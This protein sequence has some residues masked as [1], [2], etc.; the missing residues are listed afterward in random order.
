MLA[1][2]AVARTTLLAPELAGRVVLAVAARE[3]TRLLLGL[4]VLLIP[5]AAAAVGEALIHLLALHITA[6][7]AAPASS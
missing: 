6:A 2:V 4:R 1:A 7:Q 5:A 3:V